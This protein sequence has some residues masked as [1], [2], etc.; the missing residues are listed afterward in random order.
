MLNL[1]NGSV[2][3]VLL[4][5]LGIVANNNT[6]VQSNAT[7]AE[8]SI[9]YLEPFN[10]KIFQRMDDGSLEPLTEEMLS[11]QWRD[12]FNIPTDMAIVNVHLEAQK[13]EGTEEVALLLKGS[14]AD[15]ITGFG[16]II[17]IDEDGRLVNEK[18]CT[19]SCE[20]VV[21][22]CGGCEVMSHKNAK[23]ELVCGCSTCHS[24]CCSSS[25]NCGKKSEIT[26]P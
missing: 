19:C 1:F 14:T 15:N 10:N 23:G 25:K 17:S 24:S 6:T 9:N 18:K 2:L 4:S 13:V 20:D 26:G 16:L 7:D 12:Q 3:M 11:A 5:I 8:I 21:M 22:C